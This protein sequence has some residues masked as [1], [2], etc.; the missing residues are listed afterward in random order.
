MVFV[1][2]RQVIMPATLIR[3]NV[4]FL[5]FMPVVFHC[6]LWVSASL[7]YHVKYRYGSLLVVSI[8]L[9]ACENVTQNA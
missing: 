7:W 8:Y 4:I 1:K 6:F 9:C 5:G 3:I 2:G